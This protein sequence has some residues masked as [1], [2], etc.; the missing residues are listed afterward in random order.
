[1][2]VCRCPVLIAVD[3]WN[4]FHSNEGKIRDPETQVRRTATADEN[5]IV[6]LF[7]D[8]NAMKEMASI[9]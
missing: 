7:S 5:P 9:L 4:A 1:M 6:T 2:Y 3:Q 8:F